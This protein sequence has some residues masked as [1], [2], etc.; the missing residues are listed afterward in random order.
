MKNKFFLFSTITL[1]VILGI[2]IASITSGQTAKAKSCDAG[3]YDEMES[4]YLEQV[5]AVMEGYGYTDSGITMTKVTDSDGHRA[6]RV[7]IHH[8]WL[9]GI[10][11]VEEN[12]LRTD[13]KNLLP[14]DG[15]S[16]FHIDFSI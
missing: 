6:Y 15:Q 12:S 1:S 10:S 13:L 5:R 11:G 8:R 16:E 3:Y 4:Y 14:S 2:L 7:L 9:E